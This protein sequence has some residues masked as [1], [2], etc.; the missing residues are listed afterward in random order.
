MK[1]KE[2]VILFKHFFKIFFKSR[3]FRVFLVYYIFL[4][5]FKEKNIILDK[6]DIWIQINLKTHIETKML[7]LMLVLK[8]LTKT[9]IILE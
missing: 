8:I 7:S 4:L 3:K 1:N 9:V 2:Q 5:L 6:N